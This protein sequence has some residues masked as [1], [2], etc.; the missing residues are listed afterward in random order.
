[1]KLSN[2]FD[3]ENKKIKIRD[4][5]F[6][7]FLIFLCINQLRIIKL[8]KRNY[9]TN[10]ISINRA[11][12][13]DFNKDYDRFLKNVSDSMHFLDKIVSES[14][15]NLLDG[16]NF[17]K[18]EEKIEV[19]G[20]GNKI[21]DRKVFRFYPKTEMNDKEF[22]FKMKLPKDF[23][24]SKLNVAFKDGI[25]NISFEESKNDGNNSYYSSFIREFS[26][27]TKAKE[28]DIKKSID[29]NTLV[30]VVPIK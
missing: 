23:D 29:N 2:I 19:N 25:L 24:E 10:L 12:G 22:T 8:S 21:S 26:I 16:G 13:I 11:R 9:Y 30:I 7:A 4:L 6:I 27:D 5:I 15:K 14:E 18:S 20:T 17:F 3:L 28:S 1:M